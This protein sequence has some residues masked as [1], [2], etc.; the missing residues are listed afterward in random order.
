MPT[1]WDV[2]RPSDR[3]AVWRRLLG[4]PAS[5]GIV[6]GFDP[7]FDAYDFDKLG[8]KYTE[9]PCNVSVPELALIACNPSGTPL[10]AAYG[11]VSNT[12]GPSLWLANQAPAPTSESERMRRMIYN[13]YDY[14]LGNGGH[15]FTQVLTDDEIKAI[16]EYLKTL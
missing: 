4:A 9:V 8:W 16:I 14:S 6:Q 12:L 11:T 1:I 15:E 7:S 3:P 5:S 10:D 13:T 2:L